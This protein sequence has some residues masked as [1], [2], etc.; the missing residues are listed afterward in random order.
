MVSSK[1]GRI[2][3]YWYWVDG[4]FT[5]SPVVAKLHQVKARLLGGSQAAAVIAISTTFSETPAD[6]TTI[7]HDF[8]GHIESIS[9]F[10]ERLTSLTSNA[11]PRTTR[12][13]RR[14]QLRD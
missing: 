1:A 12:V 5:A 8:L 14:N 11:R 6:S 9:R 4:T 7:L 3:W 13:A 10:L 2:V